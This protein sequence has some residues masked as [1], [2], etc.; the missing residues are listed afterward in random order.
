MTKVLHIGT[1]CFEMI[2]VTFQIEW[3]LLQHWLL[4]MCF[5]PM[6]KS[7]EGAQALFPSLP[8]ECQGFLAKIDRIL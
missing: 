7:Y 8:N 4:F 1:L 3:W 5:Y 2:Q 6:A